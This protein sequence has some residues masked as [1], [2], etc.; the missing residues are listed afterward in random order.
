[1]K[2]LM[3]LQNIRTPCAV[4]QFLQGNQDVIFTVAAHKSERYQQ[5]SKLL[6]QLDYHKLKRPD[7]GIVIAFLQKI[8]GYSR[9]QLT[10]LI[11]KHKATGSLV[12]EPTMGKHGFTKRYTDSDC[13]LLA[14]LDK[15]HATP[16]GLRVKKLCE[17]AYH[18]YNNQA[19]K[20]LAK[21][22]V[23][24]IYNLRQ[25]RAYR[26]A[27]G[28][29]T[30]TQGKK[31]VNIGIRKKPRPDNKPG[32]LRIDTVHQGDFEGEKGVYHINAIDE[33]TQFEIIASVEKISE[34]YLIPVLELM[35]QSFPFKIINFHSDNGSEYI[36]HRV[37]KLLNKLNIGMTKSRARRSTDNGLVESKNASVVRK[38][39]GYSHIP[40]KYAAVMNDFN[41][42]ALNPYINYHR[43]C[44]FSKTITNKK[45]K[46]T[47]T[48]TY[49][50]V[51]TPYEKL[52]SLP[53]A[54][55]YLKPGMTF[56][57]LDDISMK[58]SD[59]E[60][61]EYLNTEREKL[62]QTI[63]QDCLKCAI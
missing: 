11:A 12:F 5:I 34:A 33:V 46:Q 27:R 36:N 23:S 22:S 62:F 28:H 51:M 48:Y 38:T 16:N 59:N 40:Q 2:T 17:R 29:Y 13:R 1:M 56:K 6:N 47:K 8:T 41:I 31:G 60:A 7:K 49:T 37:A 15:L 54:A 57:K 20:R 9:Q 43:P 44:L 63:N 50:D 35:L 30:K 55:Q 53:N 39:F 10:R 58:K 61:A 3:T 14:E 24:H 42:Q 21:I 45:G 26:C 32:F 4:K 19:Y 25:Q 52:K 18:V